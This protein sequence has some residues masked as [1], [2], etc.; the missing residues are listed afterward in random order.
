MSDPDGLE[1]LLT[2]VLETA[3]VYAR[4]GMRVF[5]C[6]MRPDANGKPRKAPLHGYLWKERA[7][8]RVNEVVEDVTAA[9]DAIG[10][11]DVGIAWA[12]GLDGCLALDLDVDEAPVWWTALLPDDAAVNVT[13]RGLHLIYRQPSDRRIGNGTAL[14]PSSGWGEVRGHGGYIVIA[15][16]DRPGFDVTQL[17]RVLPFPVPGWLSDAGADAVALGDDELRS[18]ILEH[19]T[20]RSLPG[21]IAG[22]RTRLGR[23]LETE[24]RHDTAVTV[25]CWLAREAAAGIVNASEAIDVLG[26]WWLEV[27]RRPGRRLTDRELVSI[28]RWSVGAALADPARVAEIAVREVGALE[29]DLAEL[30][31]VRP[32]ELAEAAGDPFESF[33][34]VDLAPY[35]DG[36]TA[37][38]V[39]DLLRLV[40]GRA[41]LHADRLNGIH[42]D[43]G[44]GK[45]WL[46][47]LAVRE[48][49]RSGRRAVVVDLEDTPDPLIERLRQ[50]GTTDAEILGALV[51]V[52][53]D[54]SF[55]R[56]GG[57]RLV[58][59]ARRHAVAHVFVDSLG[60][61][62]AL[63]GI[64]ENSDAEV[65]PWLAR[66]VRRIIHATGA[67]VTL[68]DHVTKTLD[69]PLH[70]S[71]SKRKRAAITGTSWLT[72]PLE[73]FTIDQG[74]TVA[75][76][77]GKD[78]HGHYRRG[79]TVAHLVMSALSD[80]G[81]SELELVAPA[82]EESSSASR[83][84]LDVIVEVLDTYG[85][86]NT[87]ALEALLER[88]VGWG[89]KY[90]RQIRE[91]AL[92]R[93]LIVERP[94]PNR[95]RLYRSVS[96][97]TD[98]DRPTDRGST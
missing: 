93:G 33:E 39:P 42:G 66:V 75:L 47:A 3:A 72:V 8:C 30:V 27:G 56:G 69:N 32:L 18:W 19:S 57:E 35:L 49:A 51:Y 81:T 54:A 24:S 82:E 7:T 50:I 60:E 77:C 88:S 71:G 48:L 22:Y 13:A 84:P 58:E 38:V 45:S 98:H 28:V 83:D 97:S 89:Q 80:A 73:P 26:V 2:P 91:L 92:R 63:D 86:H 43:S 85:E 16:R 90:G 94:G 23:W 68:I 17:S 74:G 41:L 53:P 29:V 67:G 15:A 20:N 96:P 65:A 14:F 21:K 76:R 10:E 9:I 61:A 5:P 70:P 31:T 55:V 4:A 64:D 34:P 59:V 12:L 40:D 1:D 11:A 36:T 95:Q 87:T 78:R 52:N 6:D 25:G 46:I 79:D 37:R 62:F 44:A